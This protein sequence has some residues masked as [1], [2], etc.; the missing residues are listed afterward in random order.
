MVKGSR[1]FIKDL[2]NKLH[3]ASN[4]ENHLKYVLYSV[5]DIN[6]LSLLKLL[7]QEIK[8]MPPYLADF[9]IKLFKNR[10]NSLFVS[11]SY[12]EKVIQICNTAY[13]SYE[14]FISF[15]QSILKN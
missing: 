2:L 3:L 10:E 12:N 11:I 7:E 15:L 13:C 14:E 8:T 9:Q 6:I 1:D 4:L 5:H